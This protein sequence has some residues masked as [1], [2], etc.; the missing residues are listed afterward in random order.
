MKE[1]K[2][3][4]NFIL[5]IIRMW[6]YSFGKTRFLSRNRVVKNTLSERFRVYQ[7]K[8]HL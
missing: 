8:Y 6:S 7:E 5:C 1:L 3:L 2:E 4:R